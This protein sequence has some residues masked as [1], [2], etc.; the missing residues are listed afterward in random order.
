MTEGKTGDIFAVANQN[1]KLVRAIAG[2]VRRARLDSEGFRRI[3]ARVRKEL[4]IR[5][6]RSRRLP[7]IL[8]RG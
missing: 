6:P 8:S 3:C 2:L 1:A 5:W 7:R 4:E